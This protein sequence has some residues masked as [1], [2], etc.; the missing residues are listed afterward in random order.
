M[1][2]HITAQHTAA[3]RSAAQRTMISKEYPLAASRSP[4][5]ERCTRGARDRGRPSSCTVPAGGMG[6]AGAAKEA[7]VRHSRG[8]TPCAQCQTTNAIPCSHHHKQ[9][10]TVAVGR[11]CNTTRHKQATGKDERG[12]HPRSPPHRRASHNPPWL[13][14][15]HTHPPHPARLQAGEAAAA[16]AALRGLW[17]CAVRQGRAQVAAWPRRHA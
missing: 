15:R 12:T 1:A 17:P 2:Q 6:D 7:Q 14:P 11:A 4:R 5:P 13:R 9:S 16:A 3:H 10:S 8:Y